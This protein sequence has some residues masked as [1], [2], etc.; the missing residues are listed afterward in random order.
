MTKVVHYRTAVRKVKIADWFSEGKEQV[1]CED[2]GD[3]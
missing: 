2:R 3:C 1:Y